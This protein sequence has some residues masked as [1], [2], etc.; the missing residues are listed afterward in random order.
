[1]PSLSQQLSRLA[2]LFGGNQSS[3]GLPLANRNYIVDGNFESWVTTGAVSLP[4]AFT[5]NSATM[6]YA[7]TG[8]GGAGSVA[9]AP[10]YNGGEPI[11][12]TSPYGNALWLQQTTA[13]TGTVGSTN[14]FIMQKIE[15]VMTLQGRAST[16][17]CWL[18]TASGT[19]TVSMISMFQNFGTGGSPSSTVQ[20]NVA[21]NWVVTSTP[22]RFS[23][24]LPW[25]SVSGKTFGTNGLS[26]S[27]AEVSV[28]LPVGVTFS[29]LTAQW[30]LEQSSPNAPA[31]GMPT[32]FEYRG[33]QAELARVQRYWETGY[34][35]QSFFGGALT[36][37]SAYGEVRYAVGKRTAP[38]VTQ[39]SWQ[40]FSSGTATAMTA[41]FNLNNVDRFGFTV[42]GATNWN[43]WA[44]TGSWVADARL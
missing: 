31:A 7:G 24:L 30:Q 36:I 39:S 14:P 20:T 18:W 33:Q 41:N 29:L 16:F 6:Y 26:T 27:Y 15:N 5:N 22:Q 38:T 43:G 37:S 25:P 28:Q 4:A 8:T 17:S 3:Y 9:Q 42:T 12:M 35:P 40:Y 44:G 21:V 2:A 11:G 19:M 10:A 13:S 34:Q 32:A 23:V 1:M